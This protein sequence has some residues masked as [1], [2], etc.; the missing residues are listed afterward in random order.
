MPFGGE[1]AQKFAPEDIVEHRE[2]YAFKVIEEGR[3][4][5]AAKKMSEQEVFVITLQLSQI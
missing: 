2:A 4:E 1:K 3:A 5:R